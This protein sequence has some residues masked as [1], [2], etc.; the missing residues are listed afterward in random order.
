MGA[1][2]PAPAI[3]PEAVWKRLMGDLPSVMSMPCRPSPPSSLACISGPA[4]AISARVEAPIADTMAPNLEV[5]I[6]ASLRALSSSSSSRAFWCAMC[7]SCSAMEVSSAAVRSM[8]MALARSSACITSASPL[9]RLAS[10]TAA[11]SALAWPCVSTARLSA[12][13][14][15]SARRDSSASALFLSCCRSSRPLASSSSRLASCFAR[16]SWLL[17]VIS[18]ASWTLFCSDSRVRSSTGS[19]LC[20]ST[21]VMTRPLD[22]NTN[23]SRTRPSSYRPKTLLRMM[24]AECLWKESKLSAATAP[25][26]REARA[27]HESPTKSR[28]AKSRAVCAGSERST[29]KHQL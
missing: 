3:M 26:T 4:R 13:K 16:L 8:R 10:A 1:W 14:P 25:R 27:L 9:M 29:S 15:S 28:T 22:S 5:S 12:T 20:T 23:W 7:A 6:S 24:R 18:I 11:A 17:V 19:T 21:L 2:P